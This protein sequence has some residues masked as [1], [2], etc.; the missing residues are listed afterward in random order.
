MAKLK[1][2]YIE[3]ERILIRNFNLD[4]V[5]AYCKDLTIDIYENTGDT[6]PDKFDEKFG[7]RIIK[8][9]LDRLKENKGYILGI[10]S[11]ETG[12]FIGGINVF[13]FDFKVRKAEIGYWII[14]K[15][16]RKGYLT[17]SLS[18]M[19]NYLFNVMNLNRIYADGVLAFNS[20]SYS[21]LEKVGFKREGCRRQN[22]L[23]KGNIIDDYFYGLLKEDWK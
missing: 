22:A 21:A 20:G 6:A 1:P 5:D 23:Y 3:G 15:E 11:K 17:E 18:L 16:R 13:D 12:N 7:K 10:F 8:M 2:I 14:Q 19:C 9:S 4:D